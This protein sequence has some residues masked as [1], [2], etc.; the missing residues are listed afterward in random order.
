MLVR[1]KKLKETLLY[2]GK[3]R[4]DELNRMIDM[5]NSN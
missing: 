2:Q 5:F 1:F 3:K 4:N